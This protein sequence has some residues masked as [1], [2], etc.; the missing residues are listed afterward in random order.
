MNT[1]L[2]S[3]IRHLLMQMRIIF[4]TM[5]ILSVL[6]TGL[7]WSIARLFAP[8]TAEG[9]LV[10]RTDGVACGS[11]FIAQAFTRPEYLWPR[12][13][14]V[15][16]QAAASGGSNLAPT[17]PLLRERIEKDAIKWRDQS[18]DP[19]PIELLTTSG[20]GLDPH[21]TLRAAQYQANRIASA[22]NISIQQ[23]LDMIDRHSSRSYGLAGQQPVINVLLVNLDLDRYTANRTR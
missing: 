20:S 22:R 3:I 11:M 14:A 2:D 19:V 4:F 9:G 10:Y 5:M 6:Y 12:P 7:I 16:Y 23:V 1:R 18:H 13:S 15:Q 17:N 21:I 8:Q